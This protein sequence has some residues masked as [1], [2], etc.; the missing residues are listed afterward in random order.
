MAENN[1]LSNFFSRQQG[2]A[3]RSANSTANEGIIPPY[4]AGKSV[5]DL[6]AYYQQIQPNLNAQ[7]FM[8]YANEGGFSGDKLAAM[9]GNE[10]FLPS[11]RR[12][13]AGRLAYE[14]VGRNMDGE[15]AASGDPFQARSGPNW[16]P[17]NDTRRKALEWVI[18]QEGLI[19]SKG[20]LGGLMG[21]PLTDKN[22]IRDMRLQSLLSMARDK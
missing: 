6:L 15:R 21:G 1:Y 11:Q 8:A 3:P 9:V 19:N 12:T 10:G 16:D 7:D 22:Q 13:T 2:S 18:N 14:T 20:Y 5:A 17:E 4:N